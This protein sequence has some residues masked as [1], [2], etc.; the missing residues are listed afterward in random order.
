MLTSE[1]KKIVPAPRWCAEMQQII[2]VETLAEELG[3]S[4]S[5]CYR[6]IIDYGLQYKGYLE[7]Q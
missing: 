5:E 4:Q 7:E 2:D 3:I 6:L 1:D